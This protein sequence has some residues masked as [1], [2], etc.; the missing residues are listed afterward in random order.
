M[1]VHFKWGTQF[2]PCKRKKVAYAHLEGTPLCGA[3]NTGAGPY[4]ENTK[5]IDI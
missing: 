3:N 2:P 1:I 4:F 5:N